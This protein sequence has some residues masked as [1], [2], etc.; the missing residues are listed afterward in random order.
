MSR[1]AIVGSGVVGANLALEFARLGHEVIVLEKGP[2]YPYPHQ[3]QFLETTRYHFE[4]P[5]HSAAH[6]LRHY[7]MTGEYTRDLSDEAVMRVGGAG[8][9]WTGLTMRMRAVDFRTRAAYGYGD[10]WPL[11]YADLEPWYC[12]AEERMGVSGTDADNPWSPPRTQ[13]YPL[14]PFEL[15]WDDRVLATRLEKAGIHIHTTPQARTRA[16]HGGRPACQNF[17]SCEVCPVGARYSPTFHLQQALATGRCTLRADVSVRRV[18]TDARGRARGLLCQGNQDAREF[19][20]AADLVVVA[21][22]AFESARLLLLSK[23]ARHPDGVGNHSGQLG[24]NLVFHHIWAGHVHYPDKWFAGRLGPWTGQTEQFCDPAGRG[25]YGGIKV[26][27][28]S[29]PSPAHMDAAAGAKS[30]AAAM[31]AFEPMRRCRRVAIHAESIPDAHKFVALCDTHDRFGDPRVEIHYDLNEFDAHT[32]EF[33][34]GIFERI[35]RGSGGESWEFRE[36][37]DFGIFNHYSGTCRMSAAPHDGV[38]NA[39]GA[40]WEVPGLWVHGLSTFVNAGGA[41]N[42]TLTGLALALRAVG[43]MQR[44]LGG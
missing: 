41:L 1:V 35:A 15:T 36:M 11:G 17:N 29:S 32:Y 10:D 30:M 27:F 33:G 34:K 44:S 38:V 5:K 13:P 43:P 18:L 28:P 21:G 20:L 42:P 12:A 6:D 31:A 4:D 2:D 40:V 24:R 23:D 39:D 3:Q 16:E 26:E 14:P 37:R 19:E 22:G 7:R 8:T 9:K 25:K